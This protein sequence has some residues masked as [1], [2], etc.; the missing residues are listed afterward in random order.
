MTTSGDPSSSSGCHLCRPAGV[1]N[2][3][4]LTQFCQPLHRCKMSAI[5]PLRDRLTQQ[6]QQ[7]LDNFTNLI[8]SARLPDEAGDAGARSQVRAGPRLG[9]GALDIVS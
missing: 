2:Q 5:A 7:L 9:S 3:L 1:G 4:H 8:R 6:Y